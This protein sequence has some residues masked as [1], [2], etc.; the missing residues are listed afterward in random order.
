M[1]LCYALWTDTRFY[2]V[3]LQ[4]WALQMVAASTSCVNIAGAIAV[5]HPLMER[6]F[7]F[8]TAVLVA[9]DPLVENLE[10]P[11]F[12]LCLLAESLLRA[13]EETRAQRLPSGT[14]QPSV[15]AVCCCW[16]G[17]SSLSSPAWVSQLFIKF[18]FIV[19]R[20]G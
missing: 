5:I 16:Q 4:Y 2:V 6:T 19:S 14:E 20:F 10:R 3:S 15:L 18:D 12:F 11:V 8:K 7:P 17:S 1:F 9:Q 13:A